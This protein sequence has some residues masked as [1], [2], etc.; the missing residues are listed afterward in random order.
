MQE[1]WDEIPIF[2][3]PISPVFPEVEDL[4][5]SSLCKHQLTALTDRKMAI[6]GEFGHSL[7]LT[8]TAARA[9]A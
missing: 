2:Y 7:T 6:R 5:L 8:A 3:S 4:P 1:N 9:A